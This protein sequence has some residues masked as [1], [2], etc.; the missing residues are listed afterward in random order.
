MKILKSL[1][2]SKWD[3]SLHV[4]DWSDRTVKVWPPGY[5]DL[6]G[7]DLFLVYR[8]GPAVTPENFVPAEICVE[9][10]RLLANCT[11]PLD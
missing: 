10:A 2:V 1:H 7:S 3:E 11:C 8:I 4:V 6:R 5:S 9:E